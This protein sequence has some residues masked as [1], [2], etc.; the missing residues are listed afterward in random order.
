M[1]LNIKNIH[2]NQRLKACVPVLKYM[3]N[4]RHPYKTRNPSRTFD[5]KDF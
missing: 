5:P 2:F 1:S 4:K 3:R